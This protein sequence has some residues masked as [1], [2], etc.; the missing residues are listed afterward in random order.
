MV[1]INLPCN[2]CI[3]VFILSSL[4]KFNLLNLY[5]YSNIIITLVNASYTGATVAFMAHFVSAGSC[6]A[7]QSPVVHG[8]VPWCKEES[9]G[10]RQGPVVHIS[11]IWCT[12]G[13]RGARQYH[14]VHG[15]VLWCTAGSRGA[16]QKSVV[17]GMVP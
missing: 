9:R 10:A 11:V 8:I 4:N 14:V 7:R 13:S 12:A 6:S 1:K 2:F 15:S 17:H 16:W 3:Y 5:L